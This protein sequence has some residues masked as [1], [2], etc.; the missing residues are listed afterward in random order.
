MPW[1][2]M[3]VEASLC[4]S[5]CRGLESPSNRERLAGLWDS[6]ANLSGVPARTVLCPLFRVPGAR[7]KAGQH[8]S[9]VPC[10][11]AEAEAGESMMHE[12]VPSSIPALRVETE[13]ELES[14]VLM[15]VVVEP[16]P[17]LFLCPLSRGGSARL[18]LCPG[19]CP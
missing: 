6:L 19:L 14:T 12:G 15:V 16:S 5:P 3:G 4:P 10:P 8:L 18:Y 7:V 11:N 2:T 1:L 13:P 9:L 17:Y